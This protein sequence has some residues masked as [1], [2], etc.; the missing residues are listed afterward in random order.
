MSDDAPVVARPA[1]SIWRRHVVGTAGWT[2]LLVAGLGLA[3]TQLRVDTR[4]A[5]GEHRVVPV[6][7][8]WRALLDNLPTQAPA[9]FSHGVVL[10]LLLIGLIAFAY[11]IVATLR[12]PR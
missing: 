9:V 1:R 4:N 3:L 12:L 2:A 11:A 8:V 7:D 6:L 5:R 10:A